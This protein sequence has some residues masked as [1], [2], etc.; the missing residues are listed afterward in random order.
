MV[1]PRSALPWSWVSPSF[2]SLEKP[3]DANLS[4]CLN[5]L[6][7]RILQERRGT[8]F[9]LLVSKVSLEQWDIMLELTCIAMTS[10]KKA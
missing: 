4:F 7:P 9:E 10:L 6:H 8:R 2:V 5:N 1:I 3:S